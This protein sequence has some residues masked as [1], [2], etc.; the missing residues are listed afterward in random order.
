MKFYLLR[1]SL[2]LCVAF[3]ALPLSNAFSPKA[4]PSWLYNVEELFPSSK[5]ITG[6]GESASRNSVKNNALAELSRYLK[7][8]VESSTNSEYNLQKNGEKKKSLQKVEQKVS[9][10]SDIT[11]SGVS[12]TQI[13]Y[14]KEEKRFYC[15]AYI[16]REKAWN[17]N[18][19]NFEQAKME[20]RSIYEKTL[21]CSPLKA[22]A[23][24]PKVKK[25][26]DDFLEK[27]SLARVIDSDKESRFYS[28]DRKTIAAL[29][30]EEAKLK[31][32]LTVSIEVKN[33]SLDCIKAA[34][35]KIFFDLGL[36]PTNSAGAAYAS[37]AEL[38]YN[39]S[40]HKDDEDYIWTEEPVL[41]IEISHASNSLYSGVIK[42]D[43][44]IISF[45]QN[46]ARKK[47]A[48]SISR[49]ISTLKNE[50]KESL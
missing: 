14:S 27:L 15:L 17:L 16:T 29:S 19:A 40:S 4:A 35:E 33:D 43:K 3:F 7:A 34:L 1:L 2:F 21:V 6:L 23:E 18:Q 30:S 42:G 11:L 39:E 49:Q 38:Q 44:K 24:F 45:S 26:A 25:A 50:I 9:V 41:K 28:D 8:R 5:Y 20:F 10:Q 47:A 37:K 36:V 32:K 22:L 13:Y 46:D 12:F 48:D 31:D